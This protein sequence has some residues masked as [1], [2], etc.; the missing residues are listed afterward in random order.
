MASVHCLS[1]QGSALVSLGTGDLV[2]SC[3]KLPPHPGSSSPPRRAAS[4][5]PR[6][7]PKAA[8]VTAGRLPRAV[9]ATRGPGVISSAVPKAGEGG[10]AAGTATPLGLWPWRVSRWPPSGHRGRG[11]NNN[12]NNPCFFRKKSHP[13]EGKVTR[14]TGNP[15]GAAVPCRVSRPLG[16]SPGW[17]VLLRGPPLP[18]PCADP[19]SPSSS[20]PSYA[21]LSGVQR[22]ASLS[23]WCQHVAFTPRCGG[24]VRFS[25]PAWSPPSAWQHNSGSRCVTHQQ[26]LPGLRLG[27]SRLPSAVLPLRSHPLTPDGSKVTN[28]TVLFGIAKRFLPAAPLQEDA[29]QYFKQQRS[30]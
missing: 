3:P 14:A 1:S 26:Q 29:W 13:P 23:R 22:D 30:Y 9:A 24:P 19:C 25:V 21:E 20:P 28:P 11:E 8:G 2:L 6:S 27:G 16:V 4:P 12:N 10:R 17:R 15:R 18:S 5:L 7:A